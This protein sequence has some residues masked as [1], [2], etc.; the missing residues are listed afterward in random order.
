MAIH[1]DVNIYAVPGGKDYLKQTLASRYKATLNK[2]PLSAVTPMGSLPAGQAVKSAFQI[3]PQGMFLAN[4]SNGV[5]HPVGGDGSGPFP[6]TV[7][8]N[9][10]LQS[11][12]EKIAFLMTSLNLDEDLPQES[13]EMRFAPLAVSETEKH[14]FSPWGVVKK[15]TDPVIDAT[16]KAPGAIM[17]AGRAAASGIAAAPG[18]YKHQFNRLY[19]PMSQAWNDPGMSGDNLGRAAMGLGLGAAAGA[20][21]LVAAPAVGAGGLAGGARALGTGVQAVARNA[22]PAANAVKTQVGRVAASP[23]VSSAVSGVKNVSRVA[24]PMASQA[25]KWTGI[26]YAGEFAG[27]AID[28][29]MGELGVDTNGWGKTIG[30]NAGLAK[31]MMP[32][33]NVGSAVYKAQQLARPWVNRA[34]GYSTVNQVIGPRMEAVTDGNINPAKPVTSYYRAQAHMQ[35]KATQTADNLLQE[36]LGV[37]LDDAKQMLSDA[38]QTSQNPQYAPQASQVPGQVA[39]S[40]PV[41]MGKYGPIPEGAAGNPQ[42]SLGSVSRLDGRGLSPSLSPYQSIA[43]RTLNRISAGIR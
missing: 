24:S 11:A 7:A 28:S 30:G 1:G 39:G 15:F 12:A 2:T 3:N 29:G 27:D 18:A 34:L 5:E 17:N 32:V 10:L 43:P 16:F 37:G 41:V 13:G 38:R 14:A 19:N 4:T 6:V 20:T 21:A 42:A 33:A 23:A 9:P 26:G 40:Q 8:A 35:N 31:A 25:A 36:S 22:V